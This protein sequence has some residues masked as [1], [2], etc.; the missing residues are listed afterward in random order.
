VPNDRR[1]TSAQRSRPSSSLHRTLHSLS[2]VLDGP[3]V[4]VDATVF[5]ITPPTS[6]IPP[7]HPNDVVPV[8]ASCTTG[9]TVL[10]DLVLPPATS[11]SSLSSNDCSA[12]LFLPSQPMSRSS[13][14]ALGLDL[15]R[16][17][18]PTGSTS[19]SASEVEASRSPSP[20]FVLTAFRMS[21]PLCNDSESG[22]DQGD[23]S[24]ENETWRMRQPPGIRRSMLNRAC[25]RCGFD[26]G[27]FCARHALA[28]MACS[29]ARLIVQP[30]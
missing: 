2:S 20:T 15:D 23:S 10:P 24:S 27:F 22:S 11:L 5:R 9:N 28:A 17:A 13:S 18:S 29:R 16:S 30:R 25:H 6:P 4:D 8:P 21:K 3:D 1:A 19:S 12:D 7:L 26:G 14:R